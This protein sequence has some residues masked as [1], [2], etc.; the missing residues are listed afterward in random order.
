MVRILQ[1]GRAM[2]LAALAIGLA[3]VTV[4]NANGSWNS[5]QTWIAQGASGTGS[6][7]QI[8]R[9]SIGS[10][11]GILGG[12]TGGEFR[13]RAND[14]GTPTISGAPVTQFYTFCVEVGEFFTIN[15]SLRGNSI[16]TKS[17][18]TNINLNAVTSGLYREFLRV[19]GTTNNFFNPSG[20]NFLYSTNDDAIKLQKAIWYFQGNQENLSGTEAV[21]AA[22]NKFIAAGIY[23][24]DVLNGGS[25]TALVNTTLYGG[26]QIL[27]LFTS[28]NG[29]AQDMLVYNGSS[30]GIPAVP[31]PATF[32]LFTFGL[33]GY[34]GISRR[35]LKTA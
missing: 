19:K 27:N 6:V 11:P 1:F 24:R 35:R 32:A 10:A 18:N 33:L 4:Q 5:T 31:E 8:D 2:C 14:L 7:I 13:V 30:A 25:T 23:F 21:L 15:E 26:V 22:S 12:G 34:C 20:T 3:S 28:S 29:V 9:T 16:G 17:L